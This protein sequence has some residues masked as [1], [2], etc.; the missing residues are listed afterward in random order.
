MLIFYTLRRTSP[1]IHA[2]STK[3]EQVYGVPPHPYHWYAL[4]N[5]TEVL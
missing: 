3:Q 1:Y 5:H 4:R 2:S